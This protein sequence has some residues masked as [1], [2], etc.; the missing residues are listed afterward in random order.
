[1]ST[2]VK[3]TGAR[4]KATIYGRK[5]IN[6]KPYGAEVSGEI[7]TIPGQTADLYQ[8]VEA[9]VG[10]LRS[11]NPEMTLPHS[12]LLAFETPTAREFAPTSDPE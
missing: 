8:A 10:K 5:H 11:R 12:I 4:F 2:E 9:L 3:I 1:M 6:G 7:E